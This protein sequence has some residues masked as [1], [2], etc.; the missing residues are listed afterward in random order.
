MAT[1]PQ[2]RYGAGL[3]RVHW[4]SALLVLAVYLLIEQ[5]DIFPRGSAPRAN[6]LQGHFWVGLTIFALAFWR[7]LLRLRSGT[8]AIMPALPS[9]QHWLSRL[10][11]LSL[12]AFV[13]VMPLL[14][15]ATA[16]ADGKTLLLPFT[17]IALPALLAPDAALA[18]WLE[19]LHGSVGEAFYW[20][21]GLHV[22]AALYHHV[23]R[24][25]DTLRR[26]L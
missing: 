16:W 26:M 20:V 25:D 19:D 7:V 17:A 2:P 21:I 11:H 14:G 12:Y 22:L 13:L 1:I 6:M 8:P 24:R 10:L 3:R 5:R 18:H 15:L 23:W 4:L 9:W